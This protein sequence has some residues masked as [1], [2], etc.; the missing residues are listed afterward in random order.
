M[1]AVYQNICQLFLIR[2]NKIKYISSINFVIP[3]QIFEVYRPIFNNISIGVSDIIFGS[4]SV[5]KL[6]VGKS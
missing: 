4:Y 2:R 5:G 1:I 3:L 6:K